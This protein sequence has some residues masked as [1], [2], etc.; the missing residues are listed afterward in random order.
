VAAFE[1]HCLWCTETLDELE[2][3]ERLRHGLRDE[4]GSRAAAV[5]AR[6][7]GAPVWAAAA[8]VLLAVSLI[9]NAWLL[10][11]ESPEMA[12]AATAQVYAIEA[13]RGSPTG[14]GGAA[15]STIVRVGAEA[16][17]VVLVVYPDLLR[18]EQFRATL[19]PIGQDVP[20]WEAGGI[21]A[22]TRE[23]LALTLP[24]SVLAP[25]DYRLAV[26]GMAPG[27]EDDPV[28]EVYFRVAGAP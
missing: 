10:Y 3:A 23:M 4:T 2:A 20:R 21:D 19:Y 8:S 15:P 16:S 14:M 9:G 18:H 6:R 26:Y 28:G 1:E 12:P 7:G 11:R 25:G 27:A 5:V 24:A 13:T 17:S 22:G